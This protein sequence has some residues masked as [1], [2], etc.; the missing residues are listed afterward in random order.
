MQKISPS[1]GLQINVIDFGN[2]EKH[3]FDY[4]LYYYYLHMVMGFS[5]LT[6]TIQLAMSI[7]VYDELKS[8]VHTIFVQVPG[9]AVLVHISDV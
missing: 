7:Y 9:L 5:A 4:F 6:C 8:T 2:T 1:S 3:I